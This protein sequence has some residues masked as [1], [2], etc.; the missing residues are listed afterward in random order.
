[1]VARGAKVRGVRR[2]CVVTYHII[3]YMADNRDVDAAMATIAHI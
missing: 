1:M 3:G 2:G